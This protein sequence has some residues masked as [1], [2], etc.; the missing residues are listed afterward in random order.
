MAV[1]AIDSSS[2]LKE[3]VE[4]LLLAD[5]ERALTFVLVGEINPGIAEAMT[6][7]EVEIVVEILET[8]VGG[9]VSGEL[10]LSGLFR[11]PAPGLSCF[12]C[13][14]SEME[15]F[16]FAGVI[17]SGLGAGF[18]AFTSGGATTLG[19]TITGEHSGSTANSIWEAVTIWTGVV[20]TITDVVIVVC[21]IMLLIC[22]STAFK[23]QG[24]IGEGS[25]GGG[26]NIG[27]GAVTGP[28]RFSS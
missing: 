20:A 12:L 17:I 18:S 23:T 13:R 14:Y 3:E 28:V 4:L 15:S 24:I 22:S 5:L 2:E 6:E 16:R 21:S 25:A 26:D 19:S 27:S 7:L 11:S 10:A 9:G 8:E 1:P